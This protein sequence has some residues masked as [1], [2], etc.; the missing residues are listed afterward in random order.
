MFPCL[1][2]NK[3]GEKM[4]STKILRALVDEH[5]IHAEQ[6]KLEFTNLGWFQSDNEIC[7]KVWVDEKVKYLTTFMK[8]SNPIRVIHTLEDE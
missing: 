7:S 1:R 4:K 5:M 8:S 6:N 2:F 3:Q